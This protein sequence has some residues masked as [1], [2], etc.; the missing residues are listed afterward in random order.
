MNC[1]H[2]FTFPLWQIF[3][4]NLLLLICSLSYLGW[5]A[6]SYDPDTAGTSAGRLYLTIAFL[7]GI[8]SAALMIHGINALS[9]QSGGLSVRVVLA[10]VGVSFLVLTPVTTVVFHRVLTSELILIHLWT[11][12]ALSA[13]VVLNG[14]GHLGTARTATLSVV[15]GLAT[16]MGLVCYVLY[17]R[18]DE[19][20]RYWNGMIPLI[21]V[22]LSTLVF[23]VEMLV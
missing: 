1:F 22:A 12:L 20:A 18:L 2:N 3:I 13:V 14:A 21:A 5:W 23:L 4:G 15:I 8:A 16:V 9:H 11:A 19:S 10:G 7:T 17:Y 6:V